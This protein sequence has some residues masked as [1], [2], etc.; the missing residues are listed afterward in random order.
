MGRSAC[1]QTVEHRLTFGQFERKKISDI[2]AQQERNIWL[3]AIPSIGIGATGLAALIA[4]YAALRL[5]GVTIENL[6]DDAVDLFKKT[7]NR[8]SDVIVAALPPTPAEQRIEEI[9]LRILAIHERMNQINA[10]LSAD[11]SPPFAAQVELIKEG[12]RLSDEEDAL[13]IELNN[14]AT[15]ATSWT[16]PGN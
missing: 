12:K 16:N 10:L 14:Y 4:A 11:P 5:A 2:I 15:G 3:D 1:D 13:R 7:T 6:V 8:A 9:R